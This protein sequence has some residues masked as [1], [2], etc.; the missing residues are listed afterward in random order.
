M[1]LGL[2]FAKT[3]SKIVSSP[4]FFEKLRSLDLA[5]NQLRDA[6][7]IELSKIFDSKGCT[8]SQ[9]NLASNEI[10][11]KSMAEF[12][13]KLRNNNSITFLNLST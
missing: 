7:I 2:K 6:G 13:A 3:L 5:K 10:T 12:C 4:H 9:V 1:N 11:F 8:I